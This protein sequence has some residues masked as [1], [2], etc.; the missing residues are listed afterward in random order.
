MSSIRKERELLGKLSRSE[1]IDTRKSK[2]ERFKLKI[3]KGYVIIMDMEKFKE[4]IGQNKQEQQEFETK[5]YD[6]IQNNTRIN[7]PLRIGST[8]NSLIV[9]G[10]NSK[11]DFTISK[12]VIDKCLKPEVRD[13]KGKLI[14]KT[15]H[16]LTEKQLLTALDN[17]KNPLMILRGN[18]PDSLVVVT[19]I[20]DKKDRQILV[21]LSLNKKGNSEEINDI[22]SAYGRQNF[23]DY[24]E[25]QVEKKNII[26]MHNEKAEKLF[27]SIGKKY[28]E[29]DKFIRFDDSIVYS[30]E[31]VKYP[32]ENI[33][34]SNSLEPQRD[35][36]VK[37]LP[38]SVA[39]PKEKPAKPSFTL[40]TLKQDKV[41]KDVRDAAAP[42][43]ER[44]EPT[45]KIDHMG[46]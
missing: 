34:E 40:N 18:R 2:P 24:I 32:Q 29:P 33:K 1:N 27:Q 35:I 41:E 16:G 39:S 5:F 30:T 25:Q 44:A 6:V 45:H 13:E 26:A 11:L 15:G 23:G 14:G 22:S 43:P 7:K 17:V 19:D 9:C 20:K 10:A 12:S 8:P 4:K 37:N 38:E 28:P 31:N 36:G 42:E 46:L 21:A 3:Y